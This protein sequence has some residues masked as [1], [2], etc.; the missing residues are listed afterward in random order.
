MTKLKAVS[1]QDD[2]EFFGYGGKWM[3]KE[4]FNQTI[5]VDMD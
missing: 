3:K 2:M 5:D 4:G 1:G